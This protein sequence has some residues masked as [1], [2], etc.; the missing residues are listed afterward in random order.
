MMIVSLLLDRCA[1]AALALTPLELPMSIAF[2][3][4]PLVARTA[5]PTAAV[6]KPPVAASRPAGLPEFLSRPGSAYGIPQASPG[7]KMAA[8]ARTG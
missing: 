1:A 7:A 5:S 2:T 3:L 8:A 6:H 4:P